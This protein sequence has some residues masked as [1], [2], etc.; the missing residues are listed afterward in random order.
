MERLIVERKM[1]KQ[2]QRRMTEMDVEHSIKFYIYT[3]KVS[4]YIFN[5]NN[6]KEEESLQLFCIEIKYDQEFSVIL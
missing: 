6:K 5:Y 4:L 1:A 3:K 2:T